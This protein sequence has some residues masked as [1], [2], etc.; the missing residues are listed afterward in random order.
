MEEKSIS[1]ECSGSVRKESVLYGDPL[2]LPEP[3]IVHK[4]FERSVARSSLSSTAGVSFPD[5][6]WMSY[7]VLNS[8][9]NMAAR[10]LAGELG[11]MSNTSDPHGIT[12][13]ANGGNSVRIAV[14]IDPGSNLIIALLG[15]LKLGA[16]YLPVD[17]HSAVNRVK[18]I[19]NEANP[20]CLLALKKDSDFLIN[21]QT[22]W[23]Q[24]KVIDFDDVLAKISTEHANKANLVGEEMLNA[25]TM[26]SSC[27]CVIYTSGSTGL[28]KG[29]KL[30]HRTILNRLHW[31]W[32]VHPFAN[33]EVGCFKTSLLFVDSI[34]EIFSCLLH[35][36]P[37]A[38]APRELS[39]DPEH[40]IE[41]LEYHRV[42]RLVMVPSML[43]NIYSS[44]P[45]QNVQRLKDLKLWIS[46]SET[47]PV[48]LLKE[49]FERFPLG[50]TFANYYGS[51]ETMADVTYETFHSLSDILEKSHEN[52]LSIGVP[53]TNNVVYIVNDHMSLVEEG[54]IGEICVAGG[55]VA[56]GYIDGRETHFI[57]NP[58]SQDERLKTIYKTGDFGKI[59]R[60]RIIYEGR[61]DLQ[62]KIR[63]QRVNI[64]EIERAVS[65][66]AEVEKVT[67]L[68]HTFSAISTIIVAYYTCKKGATVSTGTIKENCKRSLPSYM[69]PK[70]FH[71]QDIPLQP[72][73]GKVD[74]VSLRKNFEKSIRRQSSNELA[75]L[76]EKSKKIL[77]ILAINLNLPTKALCKDD[78]FFE[79]GGNSVSM[80]STI[81]HLK[82]NGLHI[83]I[84][85]FS[86]AKTINHI[87]G[88]VQEHAPCICEM[89]DPSGYIVHTLNDVPHSKDL[90]DVLTDSFIL[91]EPLDALLGVTRYVPI[92]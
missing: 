41:F 78:N 27:A 4:Y 15:I 81:V 26:P 48:Q 92:M 9:S 84:D 20:M 24:F 80:I 61:R 47:L 38:I 83:G 74:R 43:Q 29:V 86:S 54:D 69:L 77:N 18:H 87:M 35:L 8:K 37:L 28:P 31:Q 62:V 2:P 36:T 45:G 44:L 91:K 52:R 90:L 34:V 49:F 25:S 55:N 59:F 58:F 17:S 22:V 13:I 65:S 19:L 56:D 14:E 42:S 30:S 1:S 16:A 79:L 64:S 70:L 5:K 63:G 7:E 89:F 46:N 60:G 33:N 72:H 82:E 11:S 32:T 40:F 50:K 23:S 85:D 75:I 71:V 51:T 21:S 66:T 39:K 57:P 53:M 68:C 73:T 88:L 76:D 3:L 12:T 67:V 6:S 10:A